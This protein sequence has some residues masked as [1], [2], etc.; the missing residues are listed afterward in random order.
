MSKCHLRIKSA[1]LN[2]QTKCEFTVPKLI[3]GYPIYN[4]VECREYIV[5]KLIENGFKV[6][7][8]EP[9]NGDY[10]IVISWAHH[11]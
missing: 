8:I 10:T 3:L 1:A 5:K 2:E 7:K 9:T 4:V 11:E 6:D